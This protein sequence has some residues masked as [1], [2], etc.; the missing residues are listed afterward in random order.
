MLLGTGGTC[1]IWLGVLHGVA[2]FRKPVVLKRAA[3]SVH[4]DIVEAERLLE[5]EAH[6][7]ATLSHPN[8]IHVYDLVELPEGVMLA[9]EY[10]SGFSLASLTGMLRAQDGVLPWTISARLVADAALGLDHAHNARDPS[11]APLHVVHRDVSPE[12]LVVTEQGITKVLDFGIARSALREPTR[13]L[14]VKGKLGYHSPEQALAEP[15][16]W[17]S[18]IF[19]LGIVLHELLAG[20]PLFLRDEVKPT[21]DALL[22]GPIPDL[23]SEVDPVVRDTTR[24]MLVR[25]PA[26]RRITAREV[27]DALDAATATRG[28]THHHVAAFLHTELRDPLERRRKL[29]EELLE[30]PAPLPAARQRMELT[31][32]MAVVETVLDGAPFRTARRQ[33][34]TR[35]APVGDE[36]TV[37][38]PVPPSMGDEEV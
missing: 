7:S 28:G 15:L 33:A 4:E 35:I 26:L 21:L 27:A 9:M 8:L 14:A 13:G 6:L 20:R 1:E 34:S 5:A 38:D 29:L 25:D 3:V 30:R 10:L 18:D 37:V 22:T 31:G 16:D 2:G 12:N 32:T 24:R 17:R 11:G 19:S 23:P 36:D